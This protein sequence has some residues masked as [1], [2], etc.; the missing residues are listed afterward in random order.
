MGAAEI[1]DDRQQAGDWYKTAIEPE[2][3]EIVR[4]LRNSGIN[5]IS[6]CGHE[7]WIQCETSD[8]SEEWKMVYNVLV[9]DLGLK[10][11]TMKVRWE[12]R[13][14]HVH[15]FTEIRIGQD[16]P[17]ARGDRQADR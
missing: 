4:R 12:V 13:G 14:G 2:V 1:E 15:S 11:W 16:G 10:D 3:R 6:S 7:M 5:T 8:P 17:A 9:G